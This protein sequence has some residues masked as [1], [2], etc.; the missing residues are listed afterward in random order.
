MLAAG[1]KPN[2]CETHQKEKALARKRQRD[3]K[4]NKENMS[5]T[6]IKK[7]PLVTCTDQPL[8]TG[9]PNVENAEVRRTQD[10]D[11]S[12]TETLAKHRKVS[13]EVAPPLFPGG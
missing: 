7:S 8:V 2:R 12:D 6:Q 11:F 1:T 3:A 4:N 9:L 10:I 5:A 13:S